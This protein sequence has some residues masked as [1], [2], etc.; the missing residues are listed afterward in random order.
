MLILNSEDTRDFKITSWW[1]TWSRRPFKLS[2]L[3]LW[4]YHCSG[5]CVHGWWRWV[6]R[7]VSSFCTVAPTAKAW[8]IRITF[9]ATPF[10]RRKPRRARPWSDEVVDARC[11]HVQGRGGGQFAWG[12]NSVPSDWP[13]TIII[14]R[15]CQI[16]R[17]TA[18][19]CLATP[20]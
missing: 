5:Q 4:S 9:R 11:K 2:L 6:H 15:E 7:P 10:S 20:D 14:I 16:S 17:W 8:M 13:S 12:N 18:L 3:A 19:I 1:K